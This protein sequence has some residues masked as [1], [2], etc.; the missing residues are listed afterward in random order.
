MLKARGHIDSLFEVLKV[1]GK[2]VEETVAMENKDMC[3]SY[4]ST[5]TRPLVFNQCVPNVPHVVTQVGQLGS[6]SYTQYSELLVTHNAQTLP[7]NFD[8]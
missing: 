2:L 6:G 1:T 5:L 3:P 4:V 7:I 8:K